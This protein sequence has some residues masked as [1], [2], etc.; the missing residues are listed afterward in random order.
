MTCRLIQNIKHSCEYNPGGI[1]EIYL[2]GIDNFSSY[3]FKDNSLFDSC[4]VDRVLK[5]ENS[6][7]VRLD[8]VD[9]SSFSESNS[10]GLFR[11]E[12]TTFVRSL[13]HTKTA[14]SLLAGTGRYVVFFRTPQGNVFSFGSDGGATFSFT[15]VTGKA[16]EASGYNITLSKNSIY[17]LFEVDATKFNKILL[18]GTENRNIAC[19]EDKRYAILI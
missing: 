17:P 3:L 7:Y 16:G 19:T 4:Y 11:Q 14:D 9:E 10:N 18:L 13:R 8:V 5:K 15:Q 2:L 6:K 12:L 1:T